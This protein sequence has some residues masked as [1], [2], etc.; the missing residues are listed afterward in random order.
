[1]KNRIEIYQAKDGQAQIEVTFEK[2]TVWLTQKM[3]ANLFHTTVP[4]INIHIKNV[5]E[6]GEL[7]E[8][9]TIKDSLIVRMSMY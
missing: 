8:E 6:E 5:Y 4:N 3:M 9:G 2:D 7:K 1:M